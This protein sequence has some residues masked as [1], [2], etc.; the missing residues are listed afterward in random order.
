V[1]QAGLEGKRICVEDC[2]PDYVR[3][4]SALGNA[5]P[6]NL[7]VVPI[8]FEGEVKGVIE[9][10]SFHHFTENHLD[11]LEQLLESLGIVVAT[12]EATMRTDEL[13]RQS[14]GLADEL[15]SQQEELRRTNEEL[16]EKARQLTVQKT[17]VER[18]NTEVE[19]AKEELE[20]KA[21]QLALTS[22]YKSQ[23]LANMSH[24]LRTPLNSLLILS[25]QLA[26]NPGGKLDSK[27]VEYARTIHQSGSDL[28]SL[29]NEILDLAKIES[30]T[31]ATEF[32]EISFSSLKDY[33][34]R[35]F[36]QLAKERG[37]EFH[38][39]VSDDLP[40]TMT[41]DDMRLKQVLRNLL[42]NAFKFT[43]EG[44]QGW[45]LREEAAQRAASISAII[46][47]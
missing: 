28:L 20:E 32:E 23:F 38:V 26:E 17:E 39:E 2:P 1:G 30:G 3:L 47:S 45:L 34:E 33:V 13:L 15:Q 19:L 41:S 46:S 5:P 22:R 14:Q 40:L 36:R 12:I 9:L 27:Q 31:M 43:E 18:K 4:S 35:S 16:E 8:L 37:L 42:S 29:I 6:V 21:E 25:R 44:S 10:A 11:F 24:E 7:V